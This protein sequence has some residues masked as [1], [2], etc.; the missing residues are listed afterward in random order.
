M[1]NELVGKWSYRSYNKDTLD[2]RYN[3]ELE[4]HEAEL[5]IFRATLVLDFQGRKQIN[6]W[7]GWIT[8]GEPLK[9][10]FRRIGRGIDADVCVDDVAYCIPQWTDGVANTQLTLMGTLVRAKDSQYGKEGNVAVWIAV[11]RPTV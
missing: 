9:L 11:K 7:S 5:G 10:R 1:K 2:T 8:Y 4:I 3:G 6:D